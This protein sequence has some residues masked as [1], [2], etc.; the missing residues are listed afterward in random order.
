MGKF[1]LGVLCGTLAAVSYGLNPLF[2]VPMYR[3]GFNTASV[4]F[5][6]YLFAALLM[7]GLMLLRRK[8]FA[9]PLKQVLPVAIGGWLV[10]LSSLFLFI[11]FRLMDVG[12]A[13]TILFTYPVMVAVIMVA[14]FHENANV[15]VGVAL[16]LATIGVS[17]LSRSGGAPVSWSGLGCVL[18][19]SLTYALYIVAVRESSLRQIDPETLIF[20]V[21]WFGLPIYL[22]P[23][24]GLSL[25]QPLRTPLTWGC[26]LGLGVFPSVVSFSMIT[27]SIRL[28]GPTRAAILGALEPVTAVGIGALVFGERFTLRLAIG[29]VIILTAVVLVVRNNSKTDMDVKN[30]I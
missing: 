27:I 5:Y 11:S 1:R 4:L 12:I 25:L 15:S 21:L 23:L 8:K 9:V 6:R 24:H 13:S 3:A 16:A 22:V 2:A 18:L 17:L 14:F 30:T 29:I 10:S 20:Y 26:A 7:S 28:I 19:S